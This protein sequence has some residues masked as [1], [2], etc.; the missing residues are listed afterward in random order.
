M[1]PQGRPRRL[2]GLGNE[3]RAGWQLQAGELGD[4]DLAF[5]DALLAALSEQYCI[6]RS[7]VYSAG[8]SNGGYF[9]NLLGCQRSRDLAAIAP[10]AAGGPHPESCSGPVAA[11]ITHGRRDDIVPF[12][13]ARESLAVWARQNGC[14]MPEDL[15]DQGCVALAGCSKP[16]AFCAHRGGHVWPGDASA[17]IVRFVRALEP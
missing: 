5:F 16:T 1:A 6:D 4:R 10:T 3:R 17:A 13:S 7:R 15:P 11:L 12:R 14:A 9:S 2:P 8:M